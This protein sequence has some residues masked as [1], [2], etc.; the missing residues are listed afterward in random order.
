MSRKL[1]VIAGPTAA[2]KSDL[3]I[4]LA[5]EYQGEIISADSRQVYIGMD[6]GT[7]KVETEPADEASKIEQRLGKC[8]SQG[9]VHYLLDVADPKQEFFNMAKFQELAQEAI[10]LI[11]SKDKLPLVVGGTMLYIDALVKGYSSPGKKDK[12]LR[13]ELEDKSLAELQE[14]LKSIDAKSY[15]QIDIDNQYRLI[16]AIETK[17]LTNRSFVESKTKKK[18]DFDSLKLVFNPYQRE[19]LYQRIDQ[20][21]DLRIEQGMIKEV[22]KLHQQGL[23]W[24]R[25]EKFGL[26]YRYISRYLRGQ[27]KKS[28]MIEI[29]KNKTHAY[30]RRQLS[31]WRNDDKAIWISD[32]AQAKK[33]LDKFI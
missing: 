9:V 6:I 19:E 30:A 26:E 13:K 11:Y 28:E 22:K 24:Q 31:W 18:P 25:M 8:F 4:K 14:I 5:K 3:G 27:L 15:S 16:R 23:S 7:G 10:E 12:D 17:K 1:V 21:V 29:L 32:Y 33:E 2:G 20:R